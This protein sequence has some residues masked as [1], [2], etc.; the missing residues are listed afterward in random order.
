MLHDNSHN[1]LPVRA[2]QRLAACPARRWA[3]SAGYPLVGGTRQRHFDG[4]NLK[5]PK[6][7]KN[8]HAIPTDGSPTTMVSVLSRGSS[9]RCV[10]LISHGLSASLF[11]RAQLR[12]Y[13][14]FLTHSACVS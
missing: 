14:P 6:L 7:P 8:A 10:R 2:A 1:K 3:V 13:S 4:T 12:T 9:A 5:P 11:G